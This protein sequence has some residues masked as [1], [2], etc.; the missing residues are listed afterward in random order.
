MNQY[1]KIVNV[2][3]L[4]TFSLP[5]ISQIELLPRAISSLEISKSDVYN[6]LCHVKKFEF[7]SVVFLS[8]LIIQEDDYLK[9]KGHILLYGTNQKLT[10]K[11]TLKE[12]LYID[13]VN[14]ATVRVA[15]SPFFLAKQFLEFI[16]HMKALVESILFRKFF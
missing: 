14:I 8:E 3:I 9:L 1:P 15:K 7:G 4:L 10:A 5:S 13:A 16:S 2:L 12:P 11:H 6:R